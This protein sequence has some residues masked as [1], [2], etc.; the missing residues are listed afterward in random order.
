MR[1]GKRNAQ[2]LLPSG[3]SPSQQVGTLRTCDQTLLKTSCSE[4]VGVEL[5]KGIFS[6]LV[7]LS[8]PKADG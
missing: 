7:S 1:R 4:K 5:L 6:E 8:R 3:Q 2:S